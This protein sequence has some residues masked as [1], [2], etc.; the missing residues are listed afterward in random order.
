M[1]ISSKGYFSVHFW[2]V[3]GS[4]ACPGHDTLKYGGNTSCVEICIKEDRFIFDGGTGLR[5]LGQFLL[6]HLPVKAHLFFS[7]HH[8]DHIQGFPFFAPAYIPGNHFT[9]Y[10]SEKLMVVLLKNLL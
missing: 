4:I 8:W 9:I 1:K 3:R 5:V 6:K 7:H 2:G 10:S